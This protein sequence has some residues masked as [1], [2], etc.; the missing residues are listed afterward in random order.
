ML[1]FTAIA[2]TSLLGQLSTGARSQ[3]GT[4]ALAIS[5]SIPIPDIKD[6][7]GQPGFKVGKRAA[8]MGAIILG[9]LHRNRERVQERRRSRKEIC[10]DVVGCFAR[11]KNSNPLKKTPQS[12]DDLD[13]KFW[14]F[15]R[16]NPV[17]PEEL[18]YGDKRQSIVNSNFNS[19]K[20]T[21]I[22]AHGFKGDHIGALKYVELFLKMEDCNVV[23]VDWQKGAAGPSYPLAAANTQL[24][25]RQLAL[26]LVDI[27][28]L[29]TDPNSV[30]I[31]GFS[32]GA[33]VAG[34]AGR[35][36]QQ[37]GV[38]IG[39]IT[40]LDPAS[41]LFRQHLSASLPPLNMADANFVDVIH[42]DAAKV[43][44]NGFGL[45]N[46]LGHVDYF[47]NG[48][49]NQP[50][51]AFVRASLIVS[52]FE[53]HV[54]SSVVCN[55]AR[56]HHLFLESISNSGCQF[57]AFRCPVGHE[58]FQ[59]ADCFSERCDV[60]TT[61]TS[62]GIMGYNA[63]KVPARGPLFL[64][65]RDSS[66]YCGEQLHATVVVSQKTPTTRGYFQLSIQH[67]EENTAFELYCELKDVVTGGLRL[68]S[69]AAAKY[70]TISPSLTPVLEAQL[71]YRSLEFQNPDGVEPVT[72]AK[73]FID[74][75]TIAD[76]H[77]NRWYYC[78]LNT[79]LE[80]KDGSSFDTIAVPMSLKRCVV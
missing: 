29:G 60:N 69:T 78:G 61:G 14:L 13:T 53:G 67:G 56:A 9:T 59:Q 27:I 24:I 12:P 46:P 15:T 73:V 76:L 74:S 20:P 3:L 65:T 77:G 11:A 54:N 44:A 2:L 10:Y 64:V 16:L 80:N 5:S 47:P 26:L 58:S 38:H 23:L 55:H 17:E 6:R 42:T 41:P 48:G 4:S 63:D 7:N 40:G 32:L 1:F 50:G 36:V 37:T 62:C 39:R 75:I 71:S 30:H 51:C 68:Q 31:I 45:Y 21:K 70:N 66:P 18:V 8:A 22:V 25:G 79:V 52:H 49:L 72:L 28:S 57:S 35:A 19:S 43:W 34:F 33:H